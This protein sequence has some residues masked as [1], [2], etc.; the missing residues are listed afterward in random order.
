M[1]SQ[2]M[3]LVN[4]KENNVF[5]AYNYLWRLQPDRWAWEYLRRNPDYRADA[6]SISPDDISELT[7]CHNIRV[8]KSRVSQSRAE[9]WG[10]VMMVDPKLNAIDANVVWTKEAFP[11]QVAVDV[12]LRMPG[13][14]C[15]IYDTSVSLCQLS[16]FTDATGREYII[17]RGNG[18][19]FQTRCNGVS[20][21]AGVPVRMKLSIS[22]LKAYN[23]KVQSYRDGMRVF[24]SDPDAES[25]RCTKRTQILRDGLIALDCLEI[26]LSHREIANVLYGSTRVEEGWNGPSMRSSI[27]YLIKRAT[28]L[29]DGGFREEL[30]ARSKPKS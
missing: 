11:D 28:K 8:Y 30:I 7:V 22:G 25:P 4:I 13:E 9:H 14:T 18:C 29:R 17:T 5:N 12:V 21:L 10:M 26:G 2:E 27:R 1:G 3:K 19:L 15:D 23:R 20:L 16:H 24:G 6:M